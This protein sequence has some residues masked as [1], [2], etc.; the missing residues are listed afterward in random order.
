MRKLMR[1]EGQ[2][3]YWTTDINEELPIKMTT[4]GLASQPAM[5]LPQ[6]LI[7]TAENQPTNT[8]LAVKRQGHWQITTWRDY[9]VACRNFGRSLIKLGLTERK[10]INI[11]GFNSPEWVIA[12]YGAFFARMIP[13][14]VYTT[15]LSDACR[16]VA[17][18]SSAELAVV[19]NYDQL[20]KYLEV[21]N[22]LPNLKYIVVYCETDKAKRE[23]IKK[24]D[25]VMLWNDFLKIGK[26]AKSSVEDELD[27]EVE[28][29][30][31][32]INP[33]E[34][35]SLVY[36]SGTTGYPKGVMLSHDNYTW[37]PLIHCRTFAEAKRAITP[38]DRLVSY[39]PL[40]HVAA[41][42]VDIVSSV[43]LGAAV[44]FA[45]ATALQGSLVETL[46]E[47]KPNIF[48]GVPRVYEK[49]EEKMKFFGSQGSALQTKISTWAKGI[50][51]RATE[52]L[53]KGE[54]MP[55]GFTLANTIAFNRVKD[56]LGF[57]DAEGF[58]SGAAPLK[59]STWEY[60][61]SLHVPISNA[62]GM[63]ETAGAHIL[64]IPFV[65]NRTKFGS[66][67][68]VLEGCYIKI[69]DK[70]KFGEGEICMKGRNVFMGYLNNEEATREMFDEEGF[71][72][73]GDLGRIDEDGFLW[74]TGRKKELIITAGGENI[75]PVLI[76]DTI[77][78]ECPI[79][80]NIMIVGEQKKFLTAIITLKN[81]AD[82]Q[83]TPTLEF[84]EE[85]QGKIAEI[86]D[87]VKNI[88]DACISMKIREYVQKCIAAANERATSKAQKVQKFTLVAEDFSIA[89]GLL[90][91]TMKLKRKV[92]AKKYEPQID[93]MY[94]EPKL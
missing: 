5:S 82:S 65:P 84:A 12:F 69:S 63:S 31:A 58:L 71:I 57:S 9:L 44:Y 66:A 37:F 6:C 2:G 22:T 61:N 16:Y 19:E 81:V 80:S 21:W 47:V 54:P 17:D 53:I 25:R 14:G 38:D 40:S 11:I 86:D 4:D 20:K 50:G 34:C 33:G 90:T 7:R 48:L 41:Q 18:H 23:E 35:A 13:V 85:I 91:P 36:T 1:E 51:T 73:S 68:H 92:A 27:E 32:R 93:Q 74:I 10:A 42:T 94:E 56:A 76:E 28:K 59:R 39:L 3:L 79:I 75:P 70:D 88:D 78:E 49:M 43:T 83:G 72:R 77:K 15:N 30:L 52:A 60:F 26:R 8:A 46:K 62:Y 64:N 89:N 87:T 67:G 24:M 29:R 45:D 55:Y